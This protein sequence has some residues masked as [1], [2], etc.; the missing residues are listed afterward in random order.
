MSIFGV[1]GVYSLFQVMSTEN[2]NVQSCTGLSKEIIAIIRYGALAPSSHNA[3]MWKVKIV[4][5][6]EIIVMIDQAH[7]LPEIDPGNRES[8]ISLGAFIENIV[9]SAPKYNLQAEVTILAQNSTVQEIAKIIFKPDDNGLGSKVQ[10]VEAL[11]NRHTIRAPFLT[12]ELTEP[13]RDQL[14]STGQ[15]LNYFPLGSVV[16][17]SLKEAIIQSTRQQAANDK[18]QGELADWIRFSKKEAKRKKDGLTPEMMG[19]SGIAK[20]YVSAFFNHN[21]VLSKSF[22]EQTVTTAKIQSENCAGFVILSSPDNSVESLVNAG[23]NLERFL[24]S[25]AGMQIAV[26][27]MSAPLEESPW[28]EEIGTRTGLIQPVQMLLRVGYVKNYGYPVSLRRN[29]S[30]ILEMNKAGTNDSL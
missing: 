22:R 17:Q 30:V 18:K 28:K 7:I 4:S 24:I 8:L 26:Q 20:W 29:V 13:D 19:L 27:P 16:G 23:R 15:N 11:K 14:I 3:Q 6:H 9:E 12:K 21:S 1:L 10:R 2:S 25:A 5:E